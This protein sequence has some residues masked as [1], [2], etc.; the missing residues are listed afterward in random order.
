MMKGVI[1]NMA[2]KEGNKTKILAFKPY[3]TE[4]MQVLGENS[5]EKEI[6]MMDTLVN[7]ADN[8]EQA[9]TALGRRFM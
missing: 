9:A 3:L 8:P 6:L 7:N 1:K 4:Q 5:M 2:D